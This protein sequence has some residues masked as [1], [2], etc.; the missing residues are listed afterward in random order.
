MIYDI[1]S[2]ILATSSLMFVVFFLVGSLAG[3]EPKQAG[4]MRL[5]AWVIFLSFCG[6][7]AG[8]LMMIW[9]K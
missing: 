2:K 3:S 1:G 4:V 5:S 7:I 9:S 6:F 8:S